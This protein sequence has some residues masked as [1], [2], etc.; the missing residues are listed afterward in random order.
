MSREIKLGDRSHRLVFGKLLDLG[1]EMSKTGL[2]GKALILTHPRIM[3]LHGK[4]L[5]RGLK[6]FKTMICEIPEGEKSKSEAGLARVYESCSR[7]RIERDDTIVCFGGGVIGDLGGYAASNWSR[8]M[9]IVQVPTTLI[10]QVDSSIGGKT[11]IDW[12]GIKN[13]IGAFKQPRLI[14]TDTSVL[15]TLSDRQFRNGMAE[16]VKYGILD[17]KIWL[18][19]LHKRDILAR[20][21][22]KL[23]ELVWACA[24]LKCDVVEKDEFDVN[25]QRA[26][27]NLG[28]TIGHA[29]EGASN[30]KLLHGEA[31]ALGLIA[32]AKLSMIKRAI[33][34]PDTPIHRMLESY[35]L[36]T[37]LKNID[38]D[39]IIELMLND[40]KIKEGKLRFVLIKRIGCVS[41]PN[42]ISEKE[43][44]KVL[45]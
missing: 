45:D 39:R 8:G 38:K 11:G 24:N 44:K 35:G 28:H 7:N 6:G 22:E 2:K 21:A 3:R 5:I 25:G 34:E 17:M 37:K 43:V 10:A 23:N 26:K 20:N 4:H 14:F 9:N 18:M 41:F 13:K 1:K 32:A 12:H 36:P 31:V 16:V 33:Q 30:F 42:E 15:S 29:I 19:L 40:K 27:L